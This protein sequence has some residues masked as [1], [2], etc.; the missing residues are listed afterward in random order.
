MNVTFTN[1]GTTDIPLTSTQGKGFAVLLQPNVPYN[2]NTPDVTAVTV[3]DNPSFTED[4]KK[5]MSDIW[6][7]V[8]TWN[9]RPKASPLTTA[10]QIVRIEADASN[11]VRVT[12]DNKNL[13]YEIV[14]GTA[15]DA[16]V[17]N[18]VEVLQLGLVQKGGAADQVAP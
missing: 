1:L 10:Q 13:D 18:Y 17:T 11:S 2:L 4:L 16:P 14:A 5:A 3:G 15:H 12:T 9:N 7:L 6:K 8:T